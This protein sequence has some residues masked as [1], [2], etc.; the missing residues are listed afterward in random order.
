MGGFVRGG[1]VRSELDV[2]WSFSARKFP[3]DISL[4]LTVLCIHISGGYLAPTF[5][6]CS[7]ARTNGV[8]VGEKNGA[9]V[10]QV[11]GVRGGGFERRAD[12][13]RPFSCP[14][15]RTAMV[16]IKPLKIGTSLVSFFQFHLR[17]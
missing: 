3:G 14:S 16:E 10:D 5:H 17:V 15:R 4:L 11:E 9:R 12:R 7:H 6:V 8:G 2:I 1:Q 13:F